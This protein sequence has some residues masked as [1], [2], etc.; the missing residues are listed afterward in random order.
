[1]TIAEVEKNIELTIKHESHDLAAAGTTHIA[2]A[3]GNSDDCGVN[4]KGG[5]AKRNGESKEV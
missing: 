2:C 3:C 1:M 4:S 5:V